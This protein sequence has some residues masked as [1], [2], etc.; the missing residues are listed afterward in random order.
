M[1]DPGP[2]P[3]S[4]RHRHRRRR[5]HRGRRI[6]AV[7]V[8]VAAV[9]VGGWLA[10]SK[11]D[12]WASPF[13][14]G[15]ASFSLDVRS[16]YT[17]A[18]VGER[19][20]ATAPGDLGAQFDRVATSGQVTSPF[21]PPGNHSLEGLLGTGEYRVAGDETATELLTAMVDRFDHQAAAAGLDAASAAKLGMT[22]YQ[23]VIAASIVEK[24][25]YYP[26]N[27]P[28]VARVIVNRLA[29][30]M[31]L[32]MTST[33]LYSLGQDG[34]PVTTAD[35]HLDSPYNTY[36]HAGLTPTPICFPSPTALRAAVNPPAGPWLYFTVV[37]KDGTE[38]FTDTYTQHIKNQQKTRESG[39]G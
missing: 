10:V 29:D 12:H 1:T 32:A 30:G 37:S 6:A 2:R 13:T 11:L 36:E 19:L 31:K 35:R 9:G 39:A 18:E 14:T 25:G 24:E 34:G 15:P 17:V 22:Q 8:V 21:Q 20:K 3:G 7:A 26:K 5:R 23:V 4:A 16:G 27:M 28:K 33:V 38:A